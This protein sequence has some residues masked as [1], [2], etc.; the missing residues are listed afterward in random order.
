MESP[1]IVS[2]E[3]GSIVTR[4]VDVVF[5]TMICFPE[6]PTA[7]YR[8]RVKLALVASTR[9]TSS[10]VVTVY[11]DVFV[12]TARL[13]SPE[14]LPHLT[15]VASAL[16]AMRTV[17]FAPTASLVGVLAPD[18]ASISPL[19]VKVDFAIFASS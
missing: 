19:V 4:F 9:I 15:P 8:V 5:L 3:F 18:V 14:I 10:A 11:A 6:F 2:V 13:V 17:L 16:S 1:S 12:T 7:V